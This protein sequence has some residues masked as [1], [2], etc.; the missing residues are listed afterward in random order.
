MVNQKEK[1]LAQLKAEFEQAQKAFNDAKRL[2]E[3]KEKEEAER[4]KAELILEKDKRKKE[5][6]EAI[7]HCSK[8]LKAYI[9][10]YNTLSIT[11]YIDD[12]SFLLDRIPLPFRLFF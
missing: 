7:K 2:A 3:Q 12:F 6:D 4:K 8:L 1:T 10:D 9:E 5:V 11:D